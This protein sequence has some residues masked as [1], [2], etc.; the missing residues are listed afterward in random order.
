MVGSRVDLRARH[1]VG[2]PRHATRAR[3]TASGAARRHQQLNSPTAQPLQHGRRSELEP[4]LRH[5]WRW[6][7]RGTLERT[8]GVDPATATVG[9]ASS[10]RPLPPGARARARA[11]RWRPSTARPWPA[12]ASAAA[13]PE[14][15]A[16]ERSQL[17]PAPSHVIPRRACTDPARRGPRGGERPWC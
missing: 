3:S 14:R 1:G 5:R 11:R 10:G 15:A 8:R 13:A 16:A 17:K 12:P 4:A 6:H 2:A 7:R 9:R